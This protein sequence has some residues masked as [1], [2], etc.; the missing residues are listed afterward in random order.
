MLASVLKLLLQLTGRKTSRISIFLPTMPWK[1][2]SSLRLELAQIISA[3]SES[4]SSTYILFAGKYLLCLG[5]KV[6]K[7]S[8]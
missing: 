2:I 5:S 3:A 6:T 8:S 4:R 7:V 1:E